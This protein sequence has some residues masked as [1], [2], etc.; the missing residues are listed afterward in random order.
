[1]TTDGREAEDEATKP[2]TVESGVDCSSPSATD[3]PR[4]L[5]GEN[6][7]AFFDKSYDAGPFAGTLG[8]YLA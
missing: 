1:L 8:A 4:P 5:Q 6:I 2:K 3:C 7:L